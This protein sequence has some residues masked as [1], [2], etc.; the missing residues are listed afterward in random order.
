MQIIADTETVCFRQLLGLKEQIAQ[1]PAVG[2]TSSNS[3]EPSL[4]AGQQATVSAINNHLGAA[5]RGLQVNMSLLEDK[6]LHESDMVQRGLR[7]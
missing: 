1:S 5:L 2:H 4:D 7:S 6:T 3:K